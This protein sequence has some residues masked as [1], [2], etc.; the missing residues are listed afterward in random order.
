MRELRILLVLKYI[1]PRD[2]LDLIL[3]LDLVLC[4]EQTYG[5]NESTG[6]HESSD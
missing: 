6:H 5:S 3:R 1:T 2:T 4:P